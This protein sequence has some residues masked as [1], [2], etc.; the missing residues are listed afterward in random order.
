MKSLLHRRSQSAGGSESPKSKSGSVTPSSPAM[1]MSPGSRSPDKSPPKSPGRLSMSSV[2]RRMSTSSPPKSP[3]KCSSPQRSPTKSG[4]P[5]GSVFSSN[6]VKKALANHYPTTPRIEEKGHRKTQSAGQQYSSMIIDAEKQQK[7]QTHTRTPILPERYPV[8]PVMQAS[9]PKTPKTEPQRKTYGD[10]FPQ[11]SPQTS[12][13][14]LK[15]PSYNRHSYHPN[16]MS[17]L[18]PL[19]NPTTSINLKQ[20]KSH[21]SLNNLSQTKSYTPNLSSTGTPNLS[22]TSS[23]QV[24]PRRL[25]A[26]LRRSFD[27][28]RADFTAALEEKKSSLSPNLKKLNPINLIKRRSSKDDFINIA[29]V[30]EDAGIYESRTSREY[31]ARDFSSRD[32]VF[33]PTFTP[34][35]SH[36]GFDNS[37][38]LH[39]TPVSHDIISSS[40]DPETGVI[41][42]T[43]K[44]EWGTSPGSSKTSV[45]M[46]SPVITATEPQ[47]TRKHT[48]SKSAVITNPLDIPDQPVESLRVVKKSSGVGLNILMGGDMSR[49][50]LVRDSPSSRDSPSRASFTFPSRDS[51]SHVSLARDSP[52][53]ASF[54]NDS[55]SVIQPRSSFSR[56]LPSVPSR[57]DSKVASRRH[58]AIGIDTNT[59]EVP[60]RD[61]RRNSRVLSEIIAESDLTAISDAAESAKIAEATRIAEARAAADTKAAESASE[62]VKA[63]SANVDPSPSIDFESHD[64]L[65]HDTLSRGQNSLRSSNTG[66]TSFEQELEGEHVV[67]HITSDSA[68]PDNVSIS[69]YTKQ[70]MA[71]DRDNSFGGLLE[72]DSDSAFSF[73]DDDFGRNSSVRLHKKPERFTSHDLSDGEEE[74]DDYDGYDDDMYD[75]EGIEDDAHLYGG[76]AFLDQ[77]SPKDEVPPGDI[78]PSSLT[79]HGSRISRGKSHGRGL[80]GSRR[81]SYSK[82]NSS[83]ITRSRRASV[84]QGTDSAHDSPAG[85][86]ASSVTSPA[87]HERHNSHGSIGGR[88]HGRKHSKRLASYHS[89]DDSTS[90]TADSIGPVAVTADDPVFQRQKL[91]SQQL[92]PAQ[93]KFPPD[94]SETLELDFSGEKSRD[95]CHARD[96]SSRSLGSIT[97]PD[98]NQNAVSTSSPSVSHSRQSS[99]DK[100]RSYKFPPAQEEDFSF[101]SAHDSSLNH[102]ITEQDYEDDEHDSTAFA[103]QEVE[104]ALSE[105]ES[106]TQSGCSSPMRSRFEIPSLGETLG[107]VRN[108]SN[109]S[110][111]GS[112]GHARNL[113]HV[114]SPSHVRNLSQFS[115]PNSTG[116]ISSPSFGQT[117][118]IRSVS[119]T[120]AL[121]EPLEI[122]TGFT[123]YDQYGFGY[124]EGDFEGGGYS[125]EYYDD[126]LDEANA[127]SEIYYDEE[128]PVR[129][130][131]GYSSRLERSHSNRKLP[132]KVIHVTEPSNN[133][134]ESREGTTTLFGLINDEAEE[135]RSIVTT[136]VNQQGPF[137]PISGLPIPGYV[138]LTPISER[139]YDGDSPYRR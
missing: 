68:I 79:N 49:D 36:D 1:L 113:S 41:Y 92:S 104:D 100:R 116:H 105:I 14:A 137:D 128:D 23:H 99:R 108:L 72:D 111:V 22:K 6:V 95:G 3:V 80:S 42:A 134:V 50:S 96:L 107:H 20:T 78:L 88:S 57:R 71:Q 109:P 118:H 27:V 135:A 21:T 43:R 16:A 25:S 91:Q 26:D 30:Y 106:L 123:D 77:S 53:R 83:G 125:D 5:F 52:S 47:V 119:G 44:C 60:P 4:S 120:Q 138:E 18:D 85:I 131:R 112:P 136:P 69:Q 38:E 62:A 17:D 90:T 129:S 101:E 8:T 89:K 130:D 29:D 66:H 39:P 126:L 59:W 13:P 139:S 121:Q 76:N 82:D 124:P 117:G 115:N 81:S 94:S 58:S 34:T 56:E 98:V 67:E 33:T 15:S 86:A 37:R 48:K 40:R 7:P 11:L 10:T 73:E 64:T 114:S 12:K 127:V 61:S 74:Y 65:S 19:Q 28:R 87:N 45:V 31:S 46:E 63:Q 122:D 55:P 103:Y 51:P 97:S 9:T 54:S 2:L 93:F 70:L 133:V 32:N 35:S 84:E 110:Y 24:R 132:R 75:D 102:T